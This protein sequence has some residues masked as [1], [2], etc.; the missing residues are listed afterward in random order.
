MLL[1]KYKLDETDERVIIGWT[2][3]FLAFLAS[4]V[5]NP[6]L[7]SLSGFFVLVMECYILESALNK[8]VRREI[9]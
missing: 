1:V 8:Y 4:S 5:T 2:L 6:Y 7:A 3:A 9:V